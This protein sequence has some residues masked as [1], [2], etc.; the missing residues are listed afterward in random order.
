MAT[1]NPEEWSPDYVGFSKHPMLLE[2]FRTLR[3][4]LEFYDVEKRHSTWLITSCEPQEGK[5]TTAVNLA[6][7]LALSG[8]RVVV[9][10]ADLRR[11]VVHEYVGV[12]QSPGLSNLLACTKRLEEILQLVKADEFMPPR[13]RQRPGDARSSL[14]QRNI[15][16]L[17]SGPVPPNPAELLASPRMGK[18]I[19]D[20]GAMCDC[21][22]IDAPPVLACSDAVTVGRYADGVIVITRLG[23]TSKDQLYQVREIFD[24]AKQ[25]I[26]G[27]V[28]FEA[29][30]SPAY[31]GK[32]GY[33][34]GYGYGY[35]QQEDEETR[36]PRLPAT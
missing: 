10:D 20:L 23:R 26:V 29:R 32:R 5:S 16:V 18:L 17:T 24:R 19:A 27:A 2:P 15:Y 21:V 13:S 33:G 11:P 31:L 14:M 6:L 22:L 36:P 1:K 7:S 8:K 12:A 3:S 9:L 30:R 25:R 4:N 34:Y 28:A 35:E